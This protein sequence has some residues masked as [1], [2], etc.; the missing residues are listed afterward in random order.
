MR[1]RLLAREKIGLTEEVDPEAAAAPNFV[2]ET[3]LIE[4]GSIILGGTKQE[5]GFALRQQYFHKS[6]M[7]LLQHDDFFTKG[8]ILNR[9]SA[10]EIDGWRVWFGGDVA[11]GGMFR[12]GDSATKSELEIVC[13]HSLTKPEAERLSMP[14]IKGVSH[15]T[16]EGAKALV[17]A[18][19][20]QKE[21]FTL[22]VGY[23]GWA[24]KQLQAEL[25]R[26]S[27]YVAAADSAVLLKE[28]LRQ[29]AELG[30]HAHANGAAE[31]TRAA[32]G[33]GAAEGTSGKVAGDGLKT[34]ETLMERIG[35]VDEVERTRGSLEDRM[36]L[37]WVKVHLLPTEETADVD[38]PALPQGSEKL[39]GV[40]LRA[41]AGASGFALNQQFL[42]KSLVLLVHEAGG[43]LC[44]G[45][46][47]NRPMAK[48]VQMKLDGKPRR[49]INFGG[50]AR[51][52]GGGLDVGSNGLLWLHRSPKLAKEMT[53]SVAIGDSGVY[54]IK[55]NKSPTTL[56]PICGDP[57][58]PTCGDPI[59]PT[60][61]KIMC[62]WL[63]FWTLPRRRR[64]PE[65]SKTARP[66]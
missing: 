57:I 46:V 26:D 19:D 58:S 3:P 33:T 28:L 17:E 27:W 52:R 22:F 37:E 61:Q 64:L 40:I 10:L 23:A 50:E 45:V 54:R 29:G 9:I 43:S 62:F 2:F 25:E 15:T 4:Q 44:V 31:G 21:D 38:T 7:L 53:D 34:W 66:Q 1:A 36:L 11:E 60:C 63:F 8:I 20:A 12:G 42:H 24:P 51:L 47:L 55:E 48:M 18:E 14:I 59:S 5:F 65:P 13:L 16:L 56:F 35:K 30:T 6:V 32:E 39:P 41:G 49:C